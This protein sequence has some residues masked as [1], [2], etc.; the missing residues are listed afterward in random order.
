MCGPRTL[1]LADTDLQTDSR[2]MEAYMVV[3]RRDQWSTILYYYILRTRT[4]SAS[5][6]A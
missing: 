3:V 6:K 5:Y 1:P 2:A 4:D